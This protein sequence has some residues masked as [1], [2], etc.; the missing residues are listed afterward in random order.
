MSIILSDEQP[1]WALFSRWA[2]KMSTFSSDEQLRWALY[3]RWAIAGW[4]LAFEMSKR[5]KQFLLDEHK[6]LEEQTTQTMTNFMILHARS[7]F[8]H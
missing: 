6:L 7:V 5:D 1:R 4:A 2:K 8:S 3:T